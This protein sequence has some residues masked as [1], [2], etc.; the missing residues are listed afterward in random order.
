MHYKFIVI[1]NPLQFSK[2][3]AGS[4][5]ESY[6]FF[7]FPCERFLISVPV[8]CSGLL[9]IDVTVIY[10]RWC[11]FAGPSNPGVSTSHPFANTRENSSTQSGCLEIGKCIV[12]A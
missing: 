8:F 5:S 1:Y 9:L 3:P 6:L 12:Y 7:Y 11:Q 10:C 2:T 4:P